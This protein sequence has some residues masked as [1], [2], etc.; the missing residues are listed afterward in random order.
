[1]VTSP[2]WSTDNSLAT[3]LPRIQLRSI[4]T[5]IHPQTEPWEKL[6]AGSILLV[7]ITGFTEVAEQFAAQGAAA[8]EALS[9]VLNAYF[10][11]MVD[12]ISGHGGDILTFAGDAAWSCG[13]QKTK[14]N[15][16]N[17]LAVQCR[18]LRPCTRNFWTIGFLTGL[19][20]GSAQVSAP[21]L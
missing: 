1:M 18:L 11:R 16:S 10:G 20:C 17:A 13:G 5:G 6:C 8:V 7:D 2:S 15:L 19:L 4:A 14:R 12:V 9:K 3:F 21:G